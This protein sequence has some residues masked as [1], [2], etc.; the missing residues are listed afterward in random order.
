MKSD[1][2]I[3]LTNLPL[4]KFVVGQHLTIKFSIG[5][6]HHVFC[7]AEFIGIVRGNVQVKCL[8]G[9][10]P[11]WYHMHDLERKYPGR[12]ATVKPSNCL[13]WGKGPGDRWNRCH[14]FKDTKN[15]AS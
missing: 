9:C 3:T 6:G 14:W 2:E 10:D 12:I 5:S 8:E 11:D 13:V 4:N 7:P 15:P 1:A